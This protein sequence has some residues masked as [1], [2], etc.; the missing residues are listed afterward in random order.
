MTKAFIV[1]L[2]VIGAW[3]FGVIL[4]YMLGVGNGWE[5]LVIPFAMTIAILLIGGLFNRQ[6]LT[7]RTFLTMWFIAGIGGLI[8]WTGLLRIAGLL[9]PFFGAFGT[10]W[11][12]A[13]H[14]SKKEA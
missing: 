11:Y 12:I 6:M 2:Q 7:I 10:Y 14:L 8:M 13:T 1:T 4:V 9:L 3:V 5:I